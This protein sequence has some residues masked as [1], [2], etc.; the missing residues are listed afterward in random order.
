MTLR[1]ELFVKEMLPS[2]RRELSKILYDSYKMSQEEIADKLSITQSAVSQYLK[3]VRGKYYFEFD[4][5][6]KN[7]LIKMAEL[8]K[9]DK[10]IKLSEF[11]I[12]VMPIMRKKI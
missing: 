11:T 5:E 6:D 4:H 10:N 9:N 2:I 1:C 12:Y 3:G 7:I 8:L